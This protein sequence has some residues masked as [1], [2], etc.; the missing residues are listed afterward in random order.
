VEVQESDE[1]PKTYGRTRLTLMDIEP[2]W[3]YAYWEITPEDVQA[4][5]AHLGTTGP[6][7][8]WVLRFYEVAGDDSP[9]SDAGD[10]FDIAI[11]LGAGN[12]Y[13]NL[14]AGGKT[15]YAEA[16]LCSAAGCFVPI[17]R[18]NVV[19]LPAPGPPPAAESCWLKVECRD[20]QGRPAAASESAAGP[21]MLSAHIAA[22]PIVSVQLAEKPPQM[23][24]DIAESPGAQAPS[25]FGPEGVVSGKS[26][27]EVPP[28][29]NPREALSSEAAGSF[30]LGAT[31]AVTQQAPEARN[32]SVPRI[33]AAPA[34]GRTGP[35]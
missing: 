27:P 16:G 35:R 11:D 19:R 34:A 31:P 5:M 28:V 6:G 8:Q 14:W 1:L 15:Y 4:A 32:D 7:G 25:A 9:R 26:S 12:W 24:S 29:F 22:S 13:V 23:P 21:V 10:Y 33:N 18:S 3:L 20:E 30:G 17:C 2:F